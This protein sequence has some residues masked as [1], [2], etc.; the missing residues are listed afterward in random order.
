MKPLCGICRGD[1]W[2]ADHA[3][4]RSAAPAAAPCAE[5]EALRADVALLKRQ[6]AEA[7]GALR[8]LVTETPRA[9]T[10]SGVSVTETTHSV[11]ETPADVTETPGVTK[12]GRP[13]K[14]GALSPAQ[15]MAAYRQ[16]HATGGA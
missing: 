2:T 12:S 13:T 10:E 14:P 15:R 7:N 11:T 8:K 6:L 1:H 4:R 9:V 5:C 16:R 3:G